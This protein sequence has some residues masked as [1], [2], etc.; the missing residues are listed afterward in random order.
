MSDP[1]LPFDPTGL[2]STNY[3]E[4]EVH[5]LTEINDAT[6]RLIVP[7]FA[8][9]YLDN[10]KF[11]HRDS[12]GVL[13]PLIEDVDYSLCLPYIGATRSIGKMLYGGI[14]V[15]RTF[16]NGTIE[17]SYQSL[18]GDWCGDAQYV[19]DRIAERIYNPRITV[20]DV[21]TNKVNQFPPINHD[22][23]L[24][25]VFGHQSLVDS[26]NS[27]ADKVLEADQ[28][29]HFVNHL[30]DSTNPH[31]VNKVQVGLPD[32]ENLPVATQQEIDDKI[33]VRKYVTLDQV[34]QLIQSLNQS[35][36]P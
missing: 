13:T 8:P 36:N 22:Q 28:Q 21:V 24:D 4:D 20:W 6:Y 25:Y 15:N 31:Q 3:V 32:V 30:L 2:A 26:I 35:T 9:F 34:L 5:T 18:G 7:T 27:I 12:A 10:F 11:V 29:P 16:L 19:L 17:I 23:N 1:V 33:S 14:S